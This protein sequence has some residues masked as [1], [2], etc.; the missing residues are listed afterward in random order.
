VQVLGP[1]RCGSF[2][3]EDLA[4]V[5]VFLRG[6]NPNLG[7]TS[8]HRVCTGFGPNR[9]REAEGFNHIRSIFPWP[10]NKPESD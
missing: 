5:Q 9:T 3:A 8:L 4:R 7:G 6:V 10:I 1:V 2:D